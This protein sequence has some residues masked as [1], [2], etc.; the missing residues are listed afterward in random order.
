MFG[1]L[2]L[3]ALDHTN[4]SYMDTTYL[5]ASHTSFGWF[6]LEIGV[7]KLNVDESHSKDANLISEGG[8]IHNHD[9]HWVRGFSVNLGVGSHILVE[10]LAIKH[11]LRLAWNLGYHNITSCGF[12]NRYSYDR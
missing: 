8:V 10:L 4:C 5:D 6:N 3:V 1:I 11:G 9:D 7:F 12:R 2:R